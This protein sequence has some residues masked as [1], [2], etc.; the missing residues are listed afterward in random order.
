[1]KEEKEKDMII[2]KSNKIGMFY[3]ETL[4]NE[5]YNRFFRV[6]NV[7]VAM[8]TEEEIPP[9]IQIQER[10]RIP[11]YERAMR[12]ELGEPDKEYEENVFSYRT[13]ELPENYKQQIPW[14]VYERV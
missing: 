7:N 14:Y 1:M 8:K 3:Y 5:G 9:V 4:K 11:L 2:K 6:G 10:K 12:L 13:E